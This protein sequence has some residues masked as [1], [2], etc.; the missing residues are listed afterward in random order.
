MVCCMNESSPVLE[1]EAEASPVSTASAVAG[2][3]FLV[4]RGGG[5]QC[6]WLLGTQAHSSLCSGFAYA[7]KS[8]ILEGFEELKSLLYQSTAD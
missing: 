4:V 7:P 8:L 1:T 2:T 3:D 5:E 6:C